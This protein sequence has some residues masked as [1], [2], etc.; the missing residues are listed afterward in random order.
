V[1]VTKL[2]ETGQ[3]HLAE[4]KGLPI[5]AQVNA[6][7]ADV[8]EGSGLSS[9]VVGRLVEAYARLAWLSASP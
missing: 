3:C 9:L 6:V 8:V 7:Q 5:V 1:T 4:R 2:A